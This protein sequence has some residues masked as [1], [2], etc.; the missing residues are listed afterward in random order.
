MKIKS[1]LFGSI[2]LSIVSVASVSTFA[3]TPKPA[4][5]PLQRPIRIIVPTSTP[6]PTPTPI[7]EVAATPVPTQ[8]SIQTFS[9]LQT[10]LSGIVNRPAT[11]RGSLGIKIVSLDSGKLIFENNA[12]KYFMPA[13]NMKSY[14]VAT[15]IE[16]LTP[17]FKFVTSVFAPKMPD[18]S[19]VIKGDLTI[20]GRGDVSMSTLFSPVNPSPNYIP[21]N[22]DYLKVIEPLADK[23]I[24]SGVK[25][26]EGNL[27]ADDSYFSDDPIPGSW[28]WDDLQWYYGAEVSALPILDNAVDLAI[29]PTKIGSPCNI[30][31]LP[32]NSQ[33]VVTNKCIT[34]AAGTKRELSV[35]KKLDQNILEISG[36]FGLD[37]KGYRS[38]IAASRPAKLFADLLRQ[39]LLQKGVKITGQ[40]AVIGAKDK[41][42]Q[43]ILPIEIGRLESVP[44]SLIAAKTMKPSQNMFTETILRTLGEQLGDKTNPKSTSTD[45]G[46]SVVQNFLTSIGIAPDAVIQHDGS[47]LSRHNLVTPAS[48]V[49]L[50]TYMSKSRF[51]NAWRESLT[52]GA[53]DGTLK[54]R[55]I[56]TFA[57]N[58]VRGKTGTIDQ[59]S[60]LT[61]YV[62]TS[63]G[64][65]IVFSI[66]INGVNDGRLRN[67][68]IDE[69]VVALAGF[70]GRLN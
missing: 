45:R 49:Q 29:K 43:P 23:I 53:I 56:G 59:V 26:I 67:A 19:G 68:T 60:A 2:F 63:S 12:E 51:A 3:Q 62:T 24:A 4:P 20:Y 10:R 41:L 70:N 15:A 64:E 47:G 28:E 61:G 35:T 34:A 54:N 21:T 65:K 22:A 1:T 13:S 44:L 9:E 48:N 55:F 11:Q 32:M 40:N 52:I 58:N 69:I 66:I 46:I 8:R 33:F 17:D 16:K 25:K 6:T 57:A 18:K 42:I 39:V 50:Y 31:V 37:D 5:T 27:I 7:P 36:T 30:Q 38:S 14:T